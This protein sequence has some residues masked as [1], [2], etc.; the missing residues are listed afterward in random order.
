MNSYNPYD[1]NYYMR[2]LE[3][4]VSNYSGY[5]WMPERTHMC[6][7]RIASYLN[8][9]PGDRILD[10]G[11]ARGYY[12]RAYREQGFEAFGIDIS[13]WAIENCDPAVKPYVYHNSVP[14]NFGTQSVDWVIAKDVLEHIPRSQL[15]GVIGRLMMV[16]KKGILIIVPLS[17]ATGYKYINPRD[18][19]DATHEI[20]WPLAPWISY[21]QHLVDKLTV[22]M[23]VAGGYN[24]PGVKPAAEEWPASTGFITLRRYV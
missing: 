8:M 22:P 6:C 21:L 5:T 3:A 14:V 4:G 10:Y 24:I 9:Q 23:T 20:A 13:D 15:P 2:G 1:E 19:A 17:D 11:C 7:A 12:V 16:A 18:N